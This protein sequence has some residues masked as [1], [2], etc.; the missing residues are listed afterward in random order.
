MNSSL[1]SLHGL[2][3][4]AIFGTDCPAVT[5][6]EDFGAVL[7]EA[8]A[9]GNSNLALHVGVASRCRGASQTPTPFKFVQALAAL[10]QPHAALAVLQARGYVSHADHVSSE[11]AFEEAQTG[12]NIRLQ[13]GVFTEAISEVC[14][15][16]FQ[17]C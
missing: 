1:H 16:L 14:F 7:F 4:L 2:L 10:G 6:S 17:D 13:C 3:C 15:S 9:P 8:V 12:L 11:E 5:V